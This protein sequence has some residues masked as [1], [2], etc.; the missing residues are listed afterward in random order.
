[1]KR[2]WSLILC[3]FLL[4][5]LCA[6]GL[7]AKP[8]EK[9]A[10]EQPVNFYY[11][12]DASDF[13]GGAIQA[14]IR[15]LGP[16]TLPVEEI[17]ALYFRGPVSDN[18]RSPFP[19]DLAVDEASL[20]GGV[21]TLAFNDA[22]ASLSG[23]QLTLA[24][25]CLVYTMV[26]FEGVERVCLQTAGST[27]SG[28]LSVPLQAE[29]FL[30]VDDSD[31]NDQTTV[32]LYFSDENGRYLVEETRSRFFTFES[33]IPAYVLQQLLAGPQEDHALAALPEGT[34][35]LG[36]QT[37]GGVC[38]VNFSEEFLLNRPQSYEQARMVVF[39]VVNSLTE[40]PEIESVRILCAGEPVESGYDLDLT[41]PLCRDEAVMSGPVSSGSFDAN[42]YVVLNDREALA[43]VPTYVRR[44]DSR[45]LALDVLNALIAFKGIN[46]YENPIPNGTLVV[47]LTE[48]DG[49]C[50]VT[51][52]SSFA[53][54]DTDPEAATLAVRSVVATLCALD[55]IDRVRIQVYNS[56]L[57]HV[58]LSEPLTSDPAWVLE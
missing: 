58:D 46:G 39:S 11:Q 7:A 31:T 36:V 52:N 56:G 13:S 45:L 57:T 34:S 33:D 22:Y 26:Q 14:E 30:L 17:L 42:L 8:K 25:A 16:E 6:C 18:L 28:Q 9:P 12:A 4:L 27:L 15:D 29:D 44:S 5:G 20:S 19:A 51:F 40:L 43:T 10:P 23:V 24:N 32:K 47:D 54:C 37:E 1:M 49:L 41:Q 3:S 53:L 35:L 2:N 21:L 55:G 50:Q 38:T 48:D